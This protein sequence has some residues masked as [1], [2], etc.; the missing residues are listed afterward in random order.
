MVLGTV[1]AYYKGLV[2]LTKHKKLTPRTAALAF[3]KSEFVNYNCGFITVGIEMPFTN[4][5]E[6]ILC[7]EVRSRY[8]LGGQD[9]A[10]LIKTGA[11]YHDALQAGDARQ[12]RIGHIFKGDYGG[13]FIIYPLMFATLGS[14][15]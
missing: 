1:A 6:G 3:D 12:Q 5:G 8:R 15:L 11:N 2:W 4:V 7:Q 10:I 9:L 14:R 13:I